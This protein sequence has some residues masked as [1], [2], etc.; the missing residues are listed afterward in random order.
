MEFKRISESLPEPNDING[1]IAP[2]YLIKVDF[3]GLLLAMYLKDSEGN[4][5]WYSNYA[6]RIIRRVTFWMEIIIEDEYDSF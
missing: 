6:S 4:C 5:G 3:F 1:E 2:Y